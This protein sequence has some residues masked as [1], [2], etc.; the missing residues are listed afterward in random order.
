MAVIR[1]I[2]ETQEAS[3][4]LVASAVGFN[5]TVWNGENRV[6]P[7]HEEWLHH[8]DSGRSF[9]L[10]AARDHFKTTVITLNYVLYRI[11]KD[12]NLQTILVSES[13]SQSQKWSRFLMRSLEQRF[14]W[15]SGRNLEH[16]KWTDRMFTVPRTIESKDATIEAVG[17]LG[18][19]T[20]GHFGLGIVD[21]VV[22]MENSRSE[23][24]REHV[25]EWFHH[26][27]IPTMLPVH[28]LIVVGSAWH[29]DDLY[30]HLEEEGWQ[31]YK[32]PAILNDVILFPERYSGEK[33]A[34]RRAQ[35]G[36]PFFNCQYLL[37]PKGLVG[38]LLKEAW[39]QPYYDST[40][41]PGDLEIVQGVDLAFSEKTSADY[42]VVA[43]MG[44]S[45]SIHTI[46]LLHV[47]RVQAAFPEQLDLVEK[48][49]EE[50][51]PIRIIIESNALQNLLVVRPLLKNTLLPIIPHET[52]RDMETRM[53]AI[54]PYF[55]T[56]RI[57]VR[58]DQTDFITEFVQFPDSKHDDILSAVDL[59][60]TDLIARHISNLGQWKG[61]GGVVKTRG[62]WEWPTRSGQPK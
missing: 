62:A 53:M 39:L 60:V 28:Q 44:Y 33:L 54:S 3:Q 24:L 2:R 51:K 50:Y 37:D 1:A 31:T 20:G 49:A 19:I 6:Q 16:G 27:L 45:P 57:V 8:A 9:L 43:T 41:L 48:Q 26:T 25:D 23:I 29:Y 46:Y 38:R 56:K 4:R 52:I 42:S 15:L 21:D 40:M 55:E 47:E 18:R 5:R 34:E 35:M 32:Y 10:L 17:M 13:S 12:P 36:T 11:V 59:A 7:F 22:S 30:V 14:P 58:R 61:T